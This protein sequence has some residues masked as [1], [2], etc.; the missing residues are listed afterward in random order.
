MAQ[1]DPFRGYNFKVEIDGITS[2]AFKECSGLDS[3]TT[4]VS[5]RE[6]T[7][8]TLGQRK[9][10]GLSSG[11]NVTLRRG[12]TADR[13]LWD[14]R[15]SVNSGDLQRRDLSIILMNEKGEEQ[16]RWN[17]KNAWPAR[18]NGPGFDATSDAVAIEALELTHE[19]VEAQTW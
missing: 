17:L 9:L 10:P 5:Y 15:D 12:I 14:W 8:P 6:G 1:T 13:S 16:I 2:T 18:W 4:V 19:G 7:D 3:S 11:S